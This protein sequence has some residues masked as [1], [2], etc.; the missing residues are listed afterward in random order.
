MPDL[1]LERGAPQLERQA[2]GSPPMTRRIFV[3]TEWT[4]VPW[5]CAVELLWIGL[6][7]EDGRSWC[8]LSSEARVDPANAKCVSD[9][10]QPITPEV[11]RLREPNSPQPF[12]ASAAPSTNSGPGFPHPRDVPSGIAGSMASSVLR[13][14]PVTPDIPLNRRR[15]GRP[16]R[17]D[18]R[19]HNPVSI[20]PAPI[21][22]RVARKRGSPHVH[23]PVVLSLGTR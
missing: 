19:P 10:L 23:A 14:A 3:D 5:S 9:L 20:S 18:V 13:A 16:D 12:G 15:N 4:A 17:S 7:D 21:R 6:T 22:E 11:P 1:S 2:P 8:A